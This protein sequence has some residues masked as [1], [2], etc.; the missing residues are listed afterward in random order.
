MVRTLFP[1]GFS[2]AIYIEDG[3]SMVEDNQSHNYDSKQNHYAIGSTSDEQRDAKKEFHLQGIDMVIPSFLNELNGPE[4]KFGPMT[5]WYPE[6]SPQCLCLSPR[7][8]VTSTICGHMF[9][10]E[11]IVNWC[12]KKPECPLCRQAC[13]PQEL[14]CLYG[15]VPSEDVANE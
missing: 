10:W 4:N 12:L 11:C 6:N 13:R 2:D 14:L 5:L 15:Y 1:R 7:T 3:T 9:C 8:N